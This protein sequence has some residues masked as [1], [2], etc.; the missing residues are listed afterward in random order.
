MTRADLIARVESPEGADRELDAAIAVFVDGG[1]IVW[2][3]A[4]GTMEQYP[5]RKYQS[6]NHLGGFGKAP[7][8]AYTG[9]LDAAMMLV[10]QHWTAADIAC[11]FE[12]ALASIV[13]SDRDPRK[14]LARYIVAACLRAGGE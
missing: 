10:P 13:A 4:N 7:I 9:S 12:D 8:P 11:A 14:H 3:T 5:A 6:E 1:E 2:L